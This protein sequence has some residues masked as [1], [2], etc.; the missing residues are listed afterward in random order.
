VHFLSAFYITKSPI[1]MKAWKKFA[2]RQLAIIQCCGTVM[3]YCG[4]GSYFGE[5]LVPVPAPVPI[6]D[7][8]L[9]STVFQQQKFIPTKSCLFDTLE[10][11]L[12]PE[13]LTPIIDFLLHF[14]LDPGPNPVPE[15]KPECNT[16]PIP[17]DSMSKKLFLHFRFHNT[18]NH[19]HRTFKRP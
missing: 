3:I 1:T 2:S 12:F 15:P 7:P 18:H 9:F 8:D 5:V 10:A 17:C 14:T 4:S 11:A 6:P 13:S 19:R 16:V